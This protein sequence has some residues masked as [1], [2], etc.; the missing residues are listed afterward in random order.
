MGFAVT[1]VTAAIRTTDDPEVSMSAARGLRRQHPSRTAIPKLC[2]RC[3]SDANLMHKFRPQQRVD[4]L[5]QYQ[6]SVH[7]KRL[8]AR[9]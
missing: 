6:T 3:H 4:Q 1:I 5:A 9:R 7:G 2:A 8:A